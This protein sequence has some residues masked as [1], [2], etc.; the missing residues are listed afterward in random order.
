ME[1]QL[2]G[3]S[4]NII[5]IKQMIKKIAPFEPTTLVFGDTGVGKELVVQSLY[6][7]S[8]RFGKPFIK[9]NC[10]ALPDTLLESEM[11]G[12][13][14]GAFTGAEKNKPGIFK[15]ANGGVL[16]LDE[17]GEMSMSVQPKLLHVL[18]GGDYTP[19]GSERQIKTDIWVIAATNR[20]LKEYIDIGKFRQDLFYRLSTI[21]IKIDPLRKRPEDIPH[22]VNF[23]MQR[24][25]KELNGKI[26][27]IASKTMMEKLIKYHWPGNVR[28]LQNVLKR[29][30]VFGDD[31]K[32]FEEMKIFPE[33]TNGD[34][35]SPVSWRPQSFLLDL[36]LSEKTNQIE[37]ENLSLKKIRKI[38]GDHVEKQLISST[39]SKTGWNRTKTSKLLKISYRNLLYKIQQLNIELPAWMS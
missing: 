28:E 20:D 36:I 27:S 13:E 11:F 21:T 7:K 3:V 35:K 22:L 29:I 5:K 1:S 18:Q 17:I 38:A 26:R 15:R 6:Q 16:F 24:Y 39:L 31:E 34:C 33:E 4:E 10:A 32:I 19:L 25:T 37:P 30:A 12:Y 23:Y 8:Q 14:Q 2:I 9:V